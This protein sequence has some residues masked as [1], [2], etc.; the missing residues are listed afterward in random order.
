MTEMSLDT[1]KGKLQLF[2]VNCVHECG[3]FTIFH[4]A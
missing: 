1:G 2:S 4:F 3:T